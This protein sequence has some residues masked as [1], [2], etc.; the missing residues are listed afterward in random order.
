[1]MGCT[2]GMAGAGSVALAVVMLLMFGVAGA[3]LAWM[4]YMML[5]GHRVWRCPECKSLAFFARSCGI[6][7]APTPGARSCLG[8]CG[9]VLLAV[10]VAVTLLVLLVQGVRVFGLDPSAD[11]A[12][13]A[14]ES[15]EE[16]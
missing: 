8:G 7:G 2:L 9:T 13:P 5:M 11:D 10:M 3:I 12:P 15:S 6:C 4:I 16:E 14:S 1:M